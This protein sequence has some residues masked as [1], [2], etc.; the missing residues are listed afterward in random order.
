MLRTLVAVLLLLGLL[1][2][3]AC[4]Q[5]PGAEAGLPEEAQAGQLPDLSGQAV[6]GE[7]VA[8]L[9]DFICGCLDDGGT[10]P[11]WASVQTVNGRPRRVSAAEVFILLARTVYLWNSSGELPATVPITPQDVNPPQLDA[12][13]VP[14]GEFDPESGREINT[15][16]FLGWCG[17]T[18]YWV[19]RL[20][21]IPTAVSL[22]DGERLSAAEYLAGLAICVQYGYFE[23]D[24]LDHIFL[25]AYAPPQAW[26]KAF[27]AEAPEEVTTEEG[28]VGEEGAAAETSAGEGVAATPV[29]LEEEPAPE[30]EQ[31]PEYPNPTLVLL[32]EPGKQVSG[33]VDMLAVYSGPPADYVIF[34]ADGRTKTMTNT[35]P[36]T[37][38]WDT[39]A[40]APGSHAFRVRIY[41]EEDALLID[42]VSAYTV[43]PPKPGPGGQAK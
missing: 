27:Q 28:A 40:L 10:V 16:D 13:D 20:H 19:D 41:G 15:E 5:T 2:G 11:D 18:V 9:A 34:G 39:S 7:A 26:V 32:P 25:P 36:Y 22:V 24:L 14:Q 29:G 23:G 6:T 3:W 35:L 43:V 33:V 1:A 42:Q 38:R 31:Q 17:D 12:E 21:T 8:D 37:C 4:A 30:E